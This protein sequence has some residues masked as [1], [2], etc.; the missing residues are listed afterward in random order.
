MKKYNILLIIILYLQALACIAGSIC[1]E[2]YNRSG[3]LQS[4]ILSKPKNMKKVIS[5]LYWQSSHMSF[6]QVKLQ[7]D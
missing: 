4:E 3:I 5:H 2:I 6:L 1:L 7:D